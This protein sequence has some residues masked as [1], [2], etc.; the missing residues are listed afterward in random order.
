MKVSELVEL[1][2]E[3]DQDA[4][5]YIAHGYDSSNYE[6]EKHDLDVDER[7]KKVFLG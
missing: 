2:Q 1:L 3:L 7:N 5:V 6:F 4:E